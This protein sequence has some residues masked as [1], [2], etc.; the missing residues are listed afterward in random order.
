MGADKEKGLNPYVQM[1]HDYFDA[2]EKLFDE[3]LIVCG[4]FN[5]NAVFNPKH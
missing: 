5:S 4:D 3:N 1:I 2:N